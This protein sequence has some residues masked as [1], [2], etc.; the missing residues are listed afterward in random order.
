MPKTGSRIITVDGVRYRWRVRPAG[1]YGQSLA[2]SGLTASVQLAD[3]PGRVLVVE[4]DGP[5]PDNWLHAEGKVA[6]PRDVAQAIRQALAAGYKPRSAGGPFLFKAAAS[7]KAQ[8]L[9][10]G[11]MP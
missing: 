6:M 1:T 9:G 7:P 10:T 5:R 8:A 3:E 11:R 2:E 4:F